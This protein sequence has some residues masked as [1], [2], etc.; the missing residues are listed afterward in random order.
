MNTFLLSCISV[1]LSVQ[2]AQAQSPHKSLL[3]H[4][5]F[6]PK[7][8][9]TSAPKPIAPK[10]VPTTKFSNQ[11]ELR[12]IFQM[13]N[14]PPTFSLFDKKEN[15]AQW[16]KLDE[17]FNSYRIVDYDPNADSITITSGALTEEIFLTKASDKPTPII[18][19]ANRNI[20]EATTNNKPQQSNPRKRTIRRRRIPKPPTDI[21][22][23]PAIV[24]A[25]PQAKANY[26]SSGSRRARSAGT[27][28][29]NNTSSNNSSGSSRTTTNNNGVPNGTPG[30]APPTTSSSSSSSSSSTSS[31]SSSSS[32]SSS[33]SSSG[34]NLDFLNSPIP[35]PPGFE[36]QA[37]PEAAP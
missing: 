27:S 8:E 34:G 23:P 3:E 33:S 6:M 28:N 16:I 24:S 10:P 31:S 21:P 22:P 30:V 7:H 5:P 14:K 12:A 26:Y 25:D 32:T 1:G 36:P 17:E 20:P 18:G 4:S 9:A 35:L 2:L 13:G 11:L 29:N 19:R 37:P 15:K